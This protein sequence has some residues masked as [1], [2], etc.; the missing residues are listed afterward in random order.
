MQTL[1]PGL[2]TTGYCLESERRL[3][4]KEVKVPVPAVEGPKPSHL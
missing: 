1:L 2:I 3:S 4:L